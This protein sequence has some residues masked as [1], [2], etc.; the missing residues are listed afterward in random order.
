MSIKADV[1]INSKFDSAQQDLSIADPPIADP[2]VADDEDGNLSE[3]KVEERF[4]ALSEDT[5]KLFKKLETELDQRYIGSVSDILEWG[6]YLRRILKTSDHVDLFTKWRFFGRSESEENHPNAIKNTDYG[7]FRDDLTAANWNHKNEAYDRVFQLM[8]NT[9]SDDPAIFLLKQL[10]QKYLAVAVN[11]RCLSPRDPLR[12]SLDAYNIIG[13]NL[14]NI[15]GMR[16]YTDHVMKEM[17]IA[18]FGRFL[19]FLAYFRYGR[20]TE[21]HRTNSV[22][23]GSGV[24]AISMG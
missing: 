5:K 22:L 17:I 12:N 18:P 4:K 13:S 8:W 24:D 3:K 21:T 9:S 16:Y 19:C 7:V 6:A 20:V 11:P 1:P 14:D 2:P 23:R 10:N 15:L